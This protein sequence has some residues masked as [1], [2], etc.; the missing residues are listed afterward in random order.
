MYLAGVVWSI[1]GRLW[2]LPSLMAQN[3]RIYQR[4]VN[5]FFKVSFWLSLFRLLYLLP[6]TLSDGVIRQGGHCFVLCEALLS[7]T[8]TYPLKN[9]HNTQSLQDNRRSGNLDTWCRYMIL[10]PSNSQANGSLIEIH[11]FVWKG[12]S[13]RGEKEELA[14]PQATC[15]DA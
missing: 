8:Y 12:F 9:T 14:L 11:W 10:L 4:H 5:S 13:S 1:F 7:L 15:S 3:M 2:M 6:I